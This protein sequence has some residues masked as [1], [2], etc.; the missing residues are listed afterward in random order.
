MRMLQLPSSPS[1]VP[2]EVCNPSPSA[3]LQPAVLVRPPPLHQPRTLPPTSLPSATSMPPSQTLTQ[4]STPQPHRALPRSTGVGP[5]PR[6]GQPWV[7]ASGPTSTGV[8][9]GQR[10]LGLGMVGPSA[11][12][13]RLE[14]GVVLLTGTA[15]AWAVVLEVLLRR[16]GACL[17]EQHL[18]VRIYF[19]WSIML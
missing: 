3:P 12:V 1:T 14:V 10:A 8:V 5:T 16:E 4:P 18:Q 19:F 6:W 9:P 2:A 11:G 17:V 13:D 7:L 15:V